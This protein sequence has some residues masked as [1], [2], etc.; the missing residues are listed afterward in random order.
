M[1]D[2]DVAEQQPDAPTPLDKTT[3]EATERRAPVL[4]GF[5][6]Q[7]PIVEPEL[8]GMT[9]TEDLSMPDCGVS[10]AARKTVRRYQSA[11]RV[12]TT[13]MDFEARTGPNPQKSYSRRSRPIIGGR[14][15]V[16][17]TDPRLF[18]VNL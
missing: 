2:V 5:W 3:G 18:S 7:A 17:G 15:V 13:S 11:L 4:T 14:G 8:M 16:E 6:V 12:V 9:S 10:P 1:Q